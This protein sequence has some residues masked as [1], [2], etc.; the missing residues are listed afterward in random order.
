MGS[1][2]AAGELAKDVDGA[3]QMIKEHNE[4]KVCGF[5]YLRTCMQ[6]QWYIRRIT[7]TYVRM[8]TCG[9]LFYKPH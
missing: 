1:D 6:L 7:P 8:Y 4:R 3:E 9:L 5:I 2:I